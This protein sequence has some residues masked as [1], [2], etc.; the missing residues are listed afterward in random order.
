MDMLHIVNEHTMQ[1]VCKAMERFGE[2][3]GEPLHIRIL[4]N[5]RL[6]ILHLQVGIRLVGMRLE[7]I[8]AERRKS[9]PILLQGVN[10]CVGNASK[11]GGVDVVMFCRLAGIDIAGDVEV[12][13]IAAYFLTAHLFGEARDVLAV[14]HGVGSLLD[15]AGTKTVLLAV[16]HESLAG[17]DDEHIVLLTMLLQHHNERRNACAEEDVGWKTDD[18]IDI[19]F[20]YEVGA[21]LLLLASTEQHAVRQ[22]DCQ[23][24]IGFQVMKLMEQEGIVCLRLG[25]HAIVFETGIAFTVSR[26]PLLRVGRVADHGIHIKRLTYLTAHFL[27]W[28]VLVE[29]V[30]TTCVDVAGLYATHHQVHTSEVVGILL[31]LLGIVFHTVLV[32][33]VSSYRLTYGYKQ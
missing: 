19:V 24:A 28:P 32:G 18:G 17:I 3:H 12:V 1:A 22:Y 6:H 23:N 9:V 30:S 4:L 20:L 5:G 13:A 10:F 11:H 27:H 2:L 26:I 21:D 31:Q 14:A 16:F 8:A 33:Y 15:V 25:S 7:E 29:R